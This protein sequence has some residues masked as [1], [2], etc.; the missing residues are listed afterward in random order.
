M[1]AIE[2]LNEGKKSFTEQFEYLCEN[3]GRQ[4]AIDYFSQKLN[5]EGEDQQNQQLQQQEQTQQGDQQNQQVDPKKLEVIKNGMV[6]N[7]K[8]VKDLM[9]VFMKTYQGI[10]DDAMNKVITSFGELD[11]TIGSLDLNVFA[12]LAE[13]KDEQDKKQQQ[14]QQEQTQQQGSEQ[15][16]QQASPK[17]ES[18]NEDDDTNEGLK[19]VVVGTAIG[20]ATLLGGGNTAQA[21]KTT[22]Q[23]SITK[24]TTYTIPS[25]TKYTIDEL[26]HIFPD[27][28]ADRDATPEVWSRNRIK[29]CGTLPLKTS[30]GK[31]VV[32][33]TG[34][35][36]AKNGENPWQA[37]CSRYLNNGK[38]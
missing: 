38:M 30:E 14:Q 1:K 3:Y 25:D 31:N 11:K 17:Q 22:P 20:A 24:H 35:R 6:S 27:A 32:D 13:K 37:I 10:C 34:L 8:K 9:N 7:F 15:Q 26:I 4:F 12:S 36:A 23:Q 5:E 19:D 21:A 16:T 33:A 2:I 29:Y 28:Y 18:L